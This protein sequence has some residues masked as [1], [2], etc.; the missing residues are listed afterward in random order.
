MGTIKD[1]I[2]LLVDDEPA[3]LQMC[4]SILKENGFE[5]IVTANTALSALE[6]MSA[7][8]EASE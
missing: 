1:K 7:K 5:N 6:R 3:I 8:P 4:Q 2:I